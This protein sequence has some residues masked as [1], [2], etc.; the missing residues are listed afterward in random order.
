MEKIKEVFIGAYLTTTV[1]G[2]GV[3]GQVAQLED[4]E[5]LAKKINEVIE[6]LN[7]LPH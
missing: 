5:L 2:N 7:S 6:F 4:L 3:M 1:Y